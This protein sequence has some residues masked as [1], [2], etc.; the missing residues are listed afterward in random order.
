MASLG[1]SPHAVMPAQA[2][3]HVLEPSA[4]IDRLA[5]N[6]TR[7]G[8]SKGG[9]AM[10]LF[11]VTLALSLFA[12][13]PMASAACYGVNSK[14]GKRQSVQQTY[15]TKTSHPRRFFAEATH[16]RATGRPLIV[17]YRRYANAPAY[18]KTFIRAHECCHHSGNRNEIA[19]NCCALRRMGLS[20]RGA[21]A[22]GRYIVAKD[23]NSQT[24]VDYK[25]Q[26]SQFWSKTASQCLGPRRR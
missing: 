19:A 13:A 15:K 9:L 8:V 3:I 25:G 20:R 21:A 10:R 23:V 1:L 4:E 16:H 14:T 26:G 11:A 6:L 5:P 22:I 12:Y 24:A 17:Y 18:F 2:G 7:A